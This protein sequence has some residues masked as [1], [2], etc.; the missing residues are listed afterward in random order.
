[1][2]NVGLTV[3]LHEY[4]G[5]AEEASFAIALVTVTINNF[6][7]LRY[8]IFR[9]TNAGIC[10][11][12]MAFVASAAIF[13][14]GEYVAFLLLHTI[15]YLQYTIAIVLTLAVSFMLKYPIQRRFV[16]RHK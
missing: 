4:L 2:L 9:S 13:R 6:L 12:F 8:Y 11:Q 16:F 3:V 15:L 7:F 10:G 14:G 1:M 5:L